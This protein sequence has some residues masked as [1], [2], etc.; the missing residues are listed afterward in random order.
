[1]KEQADTRKELFR[2]LMTRAGYETHEELA[3]AIGIPPSTI[4]KW[5]YGKRSP[6]YRA[7][8]EAIADALYTDVETLFPGWMTQTN[9]DTTESISMSRAI[10]DAGYETVEEFAEAAGVV[11]QTARRWLRPDCPPTPI[12]AYKVS[13]MLNVAPSDLWPKFGAQD[14]P[15][16]DAIMDNGFGSVKAFAD[17]AGIPVPTI[18]SW[19]TRDCKPHKETAERCAR[20]LRTSVQRLFPR[21]TWE[22]KCERRKRLEEEELEELEPIIVTRR[23]NDPL[24]YENLAGDA[25]SEL[26]RKANVWVGKRFV[27]T[28]HYKDG[29]LRRPAVVVECQ[30]RWFRV[31]YAKGYCEC[32]SY[33]SR[34]H[35]SER[36]CFRVPAKDPDA[37]ALSSAM[38]V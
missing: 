15:L 23:R 27:I 19:I 1:M 11:A 16:M 38:G 29:T 22:S 21:H 3:A 33:Q 2:D 10:A 13:G 37:Q 12:M 28:T 17:V 9:H 18:T 4:C 7:D 31:R 14:S 32:F 24:D 26:R 34:L 20:I 35:E 36:R 6:R 30:D 25:M 5:I 8:A